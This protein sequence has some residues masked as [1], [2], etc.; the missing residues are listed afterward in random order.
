MIKS[1]KIDKETPV[2]IFYLCGVTVTVL[3]LLFA[4]NSKN[5]LVYF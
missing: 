4:L 5:E 1:D 3:V 2:H